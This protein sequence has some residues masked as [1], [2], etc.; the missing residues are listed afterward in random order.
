MGIELMLEVLFMETLKWS[1]FRI[2]DVVPLLKEVTP[3]H[4]GVDPQ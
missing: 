4:H 2:E 3:Y 1:F